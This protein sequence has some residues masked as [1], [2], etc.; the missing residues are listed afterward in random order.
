ML[1][2]YH[3][4]TSPASAVAVARLQRLMRDGLPAAIRG[5]EVFGVDAILPVSLDL[6]AALDTV[7]DE[8]AAEGVELRRPPGIPPT[9]LAHVVE[10]VARAAGGDM[11]WRELCYQAYWRDGRN[12]SDPAVLR[13]VAADAGLPAADVTRALDDRL[14]LLEVRQRSVADR[15]DGVGG[16]PTIRYDRSLVPG[17]LPESDLRMLAALATGSPPLG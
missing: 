5:T 11:R 8:A 2:L 17:L 7:A 13:A 9:A 14:A 15:S 12:L 4:Y 16:V 6:L 1:L 3:D 10:D